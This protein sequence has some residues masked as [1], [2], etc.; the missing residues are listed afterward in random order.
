MSRSWTAAACVLCALCARPLLADPLV[1]DEQQAPIPHHW[2]AAKPIG[3]SAGPVSAEMLAAPNADPSRWLYYHGD[4]RSVRHSPIRAFTRESVKRLRPAWLL[5][6]GT[7]GQFG[8][9]PLVYDGVMYVTTSY[10]RLYAVDAASGELLWRYDHPQPPDL[11]LCCGPANR[12][13]ALGGELVLMATLDAQLLAFERRTGKL[14]WQTRID[15][16]RKGY[17]ATGAPLVVGSRV[18]IGVGGGEFGVRGFF[19]AYDLAT[20]ARLWRHWTVPAAGEPGAETWSGDSYLRGGAP[21]WTTGS[22][23]LQT[24]TLFWG[25]GNPSPDWDGSVRQGD[26]LYADS[27]IAVDPATGRRKW[28]FQFTPHDVWDW[29]ACS[30]FLLVDL[31][32]AGRKVPALVTANR[33]G[34][35]Y[36]LDRTNGKFLR[37]Q[38][39]LDQVDWALRIDPD[40][41]PVVDPSAIAGRQPSRRVCPGSYGGLN[42]AWSASYDPRLGLAFLPSVEACLAYEVGESVFVEGTPWLGGTPLTVDMDA[43]RSYAHVLAVDLATGERRWARRMPIA[44]GTLSTAGGVL[45]TG[46]LDGLALALDA[47]TGETLWQF[48]VGSGVRGQ[49]IAWQQGGRAYVAFAAGQQVGTS[50]WAGG[51]EMVPEGSLLAVFALDA[52]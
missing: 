19:D 49:P 36:W 7:S 40:G 1:G 48:R 20:G 27:V 38:K 34:Y 45:F 17:S 15:D 37:A 16:Y 41:R 28:H 35:L 31:E 23:D 29:D 2:L 3:G 33:N 47:A 10:N 12:G 13:A 5:P 22:Y 9:S 4:T 52:K 11:R 51:S 21:T 42:G 25:T 50:R 44:A 30:Q 18:I 8:V 6:T 46:N 14:V 32:L 26:N 24:D 43:G 39:Y